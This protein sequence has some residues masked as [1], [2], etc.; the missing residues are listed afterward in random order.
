MELKRDDFELIQYGSILSMV[1]IKYE[2]KEYNIAAAIQKLKRQNIHREYNTTT[3]QVSVKNRK[4]Q[5]KAKQSL[6]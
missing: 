5:Q 4:Q 6:I 1:Q 3:E 2:P